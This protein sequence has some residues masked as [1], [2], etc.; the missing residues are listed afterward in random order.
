[1]VTL[2]TTTHVAGLTAREVFELLAHPN[3]LDYRRWWP[4]VHLHFHSLSGPGGQVGDLVVMDEYIGERRVRLEA[5]VVDA[6]PGTR[7][8]W[9]FHAGLRLPAWLSL[10]LEDADGGVTVTHRLRLGW[11]GRGRLLDPLLRLYFSPRFVAALDAH[12]RIEFHRLGERLPSA[13]RGG[14][15]KAGPAPRR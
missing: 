1:M 7:L 10:D 12:V 2:E 6:V 3:D 8:E 15:V 11:A 5:V 9:Q 4:G 13:P 14:A